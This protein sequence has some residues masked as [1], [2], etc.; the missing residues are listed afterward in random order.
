MDAAWSFWEGWMGGSRVP[1]WVKVV[2]ERTPGLAV[3][4]GAMLVFWLIPFFW[5][6][7]NG[8]SWIVFPQWWSFQHAAAGLFTQRSTVW[9]DHHLEFQ[10]SSLK[11]QKEGSSPLGVKEGEL[12]EGP[13]RKFFPMGAFGYRTRLDRILNESNRS[14]QRD[15]IRERLAA[16]V[17]NKLKK[18]A[19]E[20]GEP[21]VKEVRLVRSLWRVGDPGMAKPEGAWDPVDVSTLAKKQRLLLGGWRVD[22]DGTVALMTKAEEPPMGT[23]RLGGPP[24]RVVPEGSRTLRGEPVAEARLQAAKAMVARLRAEGR[25]PA[26][27]AGANANGAKPEPGRAAPGQAPQNGRPGV[28]PPPGSGRRPPPPP[29]RAPGGQP[30]QPKE[31]PKL[32]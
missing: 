23:V 1:T 14:P 16:H 12:Y 32:K 15:A 31:V 25:L 28:P 29:M 3:Y 19:E 6:G 7:Q 18:E 4:G 10:G 24:S 17:A 22:A 8:R 11:V 2:W 5:V 9:W 30:L 26:A 21:V 27:P 20:S 13:E